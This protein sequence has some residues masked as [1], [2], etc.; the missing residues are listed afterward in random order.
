VTAAGGL[1]DRPYN[2]LPVSM[3][4]NVRASADLTRQCADICVHDTGKG[5]PHAHIMLTMRPIEKDGKLGQK[6]HTVNGRKINTVD[7]SDRDKAE[8]WRRAWAAYANGA[9]RIAG[10]QN[11][12]NI[13]D[14][15]SYE[16][17]GI[18][19]QPT[20]HCGLRNYKNGL[21]KNAKPSRRGSLILYH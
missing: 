21:P 1:D 11:E 10:L 12:D 8:E 9:L 3:M 17:Q 6:S 20:V 19:Q 2:K 7:W 5:N 13:L 14:H 4:K 16:R 15:R 18:K